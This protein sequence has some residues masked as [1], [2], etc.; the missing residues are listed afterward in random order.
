MCRIEHRLADGSS[1]PHLTQAVVL[2]A[3][4]DGIE[5]K[6]GKMS[7]VIEYTSEDTLMS[8]V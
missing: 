5:K 1:N 3:G 7:V 8:P 6:T 4:L 2:A